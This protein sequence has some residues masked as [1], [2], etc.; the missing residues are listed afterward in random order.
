MFQKRNG[1]WNMNGNKNNGYMGMNEN[2][3]DRSESD[4]GNN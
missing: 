4:E 3:G 1:P 2:L